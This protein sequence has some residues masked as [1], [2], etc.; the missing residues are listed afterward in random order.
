MHRIG[1]SACKANSSHTPHRR[2][3][4]AASYRLAVLWVGCQ[5]V[6]MSSAPVCAP[7]IRAKANWVADRQPICSLKLVSGS[8][9]GIRRGLWTATPPL[10]MYRA[11]TGSDLTSF[12]PS[13]L[14]RTLCSSFQNALLLHR[15]GLAPFQHCCGRINWHEHEGRTTPPESTN[16]RIADCGKATIVQGLLRC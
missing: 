8:H 2:C 3:R 13:P 6:A 12:C 5:A 1:F 14:F 7:V 16:R 9:P 10:C 4:A 11:C 15:T